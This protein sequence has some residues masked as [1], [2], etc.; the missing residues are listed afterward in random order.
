[1]QCT[2]DSR[3]L[4]YKLIVSRY[5]AELITT[6]AGCFGHIALCQLHTEQCTVLCAVDKGLHGRNVLH[7]LTHGAL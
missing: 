1:M 5:V 4:W 2:R 7:Q 3:E 6:D